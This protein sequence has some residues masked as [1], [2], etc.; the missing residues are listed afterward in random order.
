MKSTLANEIVHYSERLIRDDEVVDSIKSEFC[1]KYC[2][3][4]RDAKDQEELDS[5]CD[6]CTLNIVKGF[7][8]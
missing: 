6:E 5:I 4:P 3:Q 7:I 8:F 1:D 2:K